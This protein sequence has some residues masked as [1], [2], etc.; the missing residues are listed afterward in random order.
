LAN[1]PKPGKPAVAFEDVTVKSRIGDKP[2]PGLG[3]TVADFDGDGWPD[4]FVAN[5]QAPNHLFMNKHDGTFTEEALARGVARTA[6][7]NTYAGM[8][9]GAGDVDNDGLLDLYVT[10]LSSETN[11]LWKQGPRGQFRDLTGS[12]GLTTTRWRGTG[13][14]TVMADFDLDGWLDI[15][16]VNGRVYQDPK[17]P[18][19]PGIAPH[20]QPYA[21][22]NQV[23]SNTGSGQ[24][25]DISQ[26]N[27]ALCGYYTM[28]RGLACGD[29]DGDGAPDLLVTAIGEKARLLRNVAPQRGDWVAVTAFD[30]TLNRAAIGA[31]V[32]AISKGVRRLRIL[33]SGD[34]YLSAGPLVAH[35]GLGAANRIEKFEIHWPDGT[36]EWFE[37]GAVNRHVELR[38]GTGNK[39]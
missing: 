37:G 3:V 12:W 25:R 32:Y 1:D 26:N 22:R 35:F 33:G 24:F 17:P 16:I 15:A 2:G 14:G 18:V 7:G 13:F 21:E 9:V 11:T 38:K 6:M 27:P 28:G 19:K 10:H 20:W 34:S 8:G 4:I 36:R 23:F 31:E 29:F 5:D 39:L 30:P